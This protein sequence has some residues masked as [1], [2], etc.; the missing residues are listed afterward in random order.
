[1]H[2]RGNGAQGKMPMHSEGTGTGTDAD[3]AFAGYYG[4][5]RHALLTLLPA[6]LAPRHVLE[7][8]CGSGANLAALKLRFPGCSTTG[9][10]VDTRASHAARQRQGVDTVVQGDV[11]S[12]D[13]PDA[14]FDLIVLSHVLEHFAEPAAVLQRML[15]W[16]TPTGKLLVALPNVRHAS[17]LAELVFLRDFRY[18]PAGILDRTHL[19]FFTRRSAVRLFAEQGLVV[20]RWAPDIHG[21]KSKLVLWCSLGMAR[22]LAA[23]AHN[24]L[25]RR[26]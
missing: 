23:F 25:L 9:V 16:L 26:P 1:M 12:I 3:A 18:R 7:V 24:F 4:T 20:E 15:R 6:D 10:E 13:L 8:G 5:A 21:L 22:D 11:L 14:G 2:R 19:R 17:V